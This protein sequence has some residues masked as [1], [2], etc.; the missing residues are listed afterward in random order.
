MESR[1]K[2]NFLSFSLLHLRI[3][4]RA[5]DPYLIWI[6]QIE[7]TSSYKKNLDERAHKRH[8]T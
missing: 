1:R 2:L 4:I 6:D 3:S 8:E 7:T 5:K